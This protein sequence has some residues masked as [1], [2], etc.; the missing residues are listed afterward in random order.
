MTGVLRTMGSDLLDLFFPAL[1]S[2]CR[3]TLLDG[4]RSL[5]TRCR[6]S[7][8][9]TGYHT[10]P[11]NPVEKRFW[12]RTDVDRAAAFL[13]FEKGMGVQRVLR[14]LKYGGIEAVGEHLGRLYARDLAGTDFARVDAVTAVPLHP[15][16]ERQRG[17]NQSHAFGRALAD[18]LGVR[19]RPDLLRRVRHLHS[20]TRMGREARWTRLQ[21][22]FMAG[23]DDLEPGRT[24]LLVDDVITTGA[25][26]EACTRVLLTTPGTT[27]RVATIACAD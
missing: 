7:L 9:R 22:A 25:T 18:G 12:G 16:R 17:Y 27:V 15:R 26:L 1:C 19:W 24:I 21:N 11:A 14:D 23:R 6:V 5:C 8:P 10:M 13:F 20:Q 4:E 3:G 2:S